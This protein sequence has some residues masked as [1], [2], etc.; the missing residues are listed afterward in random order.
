MAIF[1]TTSYPLSSLVEDISQGK[2]GLPEIQ[3]PFVWPNVNVRN[4][5]D[6]LYREYPAGYLLFWETGAEAV[7]KTIG[8]HHHQK[9]PT[10]AIVDGQQR[11]TSLYAVIKGQEVVRAN[12]KRERIRIAFNP[13]QARFDVTDASIVKDKSYIHDISVL[14]R[15]DAN[16]FDFAASFIAELQSVRELSNDEVA[17]VQ[18]AIGRLHQLPQYSFTALTLS[19]SVDAETVA[20]VFVRINGQGKQLNQADFILTLMSVFW[21]EGRVELEQFARAA[22]APGDGS[23][24]PFNHFI[25]P[26][27]DQMLRVTVG[28]GLKR[29]RLEAVYSVLR[30]RDVTTGQVDNEKRDAQFALLR[31]AQSRAL[32]LANWHHFLS[33]LRIAG[34]RHE[35]MLSSQTAVIYSYVL[36]LLGIIDYRIPKQEMRQAIAQFFFMA[37]MTGRYTSSPETRFEFDIAQL[38]TSKDAQDYLGRLRQIC[39]QT[40]TNDFWEMT[41][42][43]ALATSAARSPSRFAYQAS[44]MLLGARALY[45]PLTITDMVDPEIRGPKAT[46]EQHHL[47]PKGYLAKLGI[48]DSRVTNQIANFAVVEWPDNIKISDQSPEE[49]AAPLDATMSAAERERMLHWHALPS[50]WWTLPYDEFLLERRARMARVVEEAYTRL[51]GSS[52]VLAAPLSV[53]ELLAGGE[54]GNVEFKS[55]LRTNLHTGQHDEKMHLAA[56]KSI[57]GFLNAKGGTLVIGVSDDGKVLGLASDGF[58]NEDK[59]ALHLGNL[60]RDRIGELFAPYVHAHFH[61]QDNERLLIVQCDPGPRPAFIKDGGAQRLFVRGGNVTIELAG[62]AIMDY[63]RARFS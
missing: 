53:A 15:A 44:L 47:F 10:L 8:T 6:S 42:P 56:L 2:I 60:I 35:G 61:E 39:A 32:N 50:G 17:R 28:L 45:S 26:S 19:G 29:A 55:T 46:F 13:L 25:S 20:E 63:S 59:M 27:P 1:T 43:T 24:S 33:G 14:W 34:Y 23:A 51:C 12:F 18:K 16:L 22:S 38:K 4:L 30:G 9:A 37:S 54:G 62:N 7:T 48:T 40:L 49:Y 3:R 57:A 41:L 58:L 31:A 11:L 21:D 52:P 36:Y 5:L